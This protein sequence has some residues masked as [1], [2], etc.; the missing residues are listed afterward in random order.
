MLIHIST[1]RNI[2]HDLFARGIITQKE[3]SDFLGE[4][5]QA[6]R[7]RARNID[8]KIARAKFVSDILQSE[9]A[10]TSRGP[11]RKSQ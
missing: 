3:A 10:K 2:A 7:Y 9:I 5:K 6:F 8:W 4:S 11:K 1:K